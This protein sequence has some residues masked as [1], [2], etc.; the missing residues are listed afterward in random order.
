M[1]DWLNA[2]PTT[3]DGRQAVPLALWQLMQAN[4][5]VLMG[6]ATTVAGGVVVALPVA[7]TAQL[8]AGAGIND[9]R[10]MLAKQSFKPNGGDPHVLS[11]DKTTSQFKIQNSGTEY[12]DVIFYIVFWTGA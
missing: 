7:F 11:A 6:I 3:I 10:V 1:A 9:Y 2:V 8:N 5:P 12:G 4:I